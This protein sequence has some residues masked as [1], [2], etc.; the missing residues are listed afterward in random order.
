MAW[1]HLLIC[2]TIELA[3]TL[4]L[5]SGVAIFQF[6]VIL[7]IQVP[8]QLPERAS[9]LF[10]DPLII[11][12]LYYRSLSVHTVKIIRVNHTR[13]V[14]KVKRIISLIKFACRLSDGP[15]PAQANLAQSG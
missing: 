14:I 12:A 2:F 3:L 15:L 9:C 13:A 1:I 11:Q 7:L 4:Q 6:C 8:V 10:T 5:D